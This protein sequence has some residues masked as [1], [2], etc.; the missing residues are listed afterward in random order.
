MPLL[1]SSSR[2]AIILNKRSCRGIDRCIKVGFQVNPTWKINSYK[3]CN[4]CT[5]SVWLKK[6]KC[7]VLYTRLGSHKCL[8]CRSSTMNKWYHSK[9]ESTTTIRRTTM[10][11]NKGKEE[12]LWWWACK[13]VAIA[14]SLMKMK[15]NILSKTNCSGA[16]QLGDSHQGT[17]IGIRS[18][19]IRVI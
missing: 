8:S 10:P 15:I 2:K 11:P 1:A 13:T 9:V 4:K 19:N 3:C 7:W 5:S 16:F 17:K 12:L 6:A 18:H 14:L